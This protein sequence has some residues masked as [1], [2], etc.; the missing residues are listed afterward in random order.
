MMF[1]REAMERAQEQARG[2]RILITIASAFIAAIVLP[3]LWSAFISKSK[4]DPS[5]PAPVKV[6]PVPPARS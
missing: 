4:P 5:R 1:E 2:R 6:A 3:I